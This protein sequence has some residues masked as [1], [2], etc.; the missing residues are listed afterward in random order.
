MATEAGGCHVELTFAN[1]STATVDVVINLLG[2]IGC[3]S[4]PHGCG[5][6]LSA[7]PSLTSLGNHCAESG[8]DAE[9]LG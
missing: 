5:P 7:T 3:G 8:A 2:W 6:V 4:N 1:G 9:P